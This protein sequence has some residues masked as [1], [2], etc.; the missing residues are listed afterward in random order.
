MQYVMCQLPNEKELTYIPYVGKN[1]GVGKVRKL[2]ADF[3]CELFLVE[4]VSATHRVHSPIFYPPICSSYL[5][6]QCVTPPKF[7]GI[8]VI[9]NV[10]VS[11][12]TSM[13]TYKPDQLSILIMVNLSDFVTNF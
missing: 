13:I 2:F 11:F 8:K 10:L 5:I 3:T 9:K 4:S 7:S 12:I 1:F 6:C